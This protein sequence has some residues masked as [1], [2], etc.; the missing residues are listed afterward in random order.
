M[1]KAGNTG[2]NIV[3]FDLSVK[4]YTCHNDAPKAD[5]G[6]PASGA[7]KCVSCNLG[8]TISHDCTKVYSYV[9]L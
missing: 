5:V 2:S 7:P 8:F 4:V 6:C 1:H 9:C 3:H